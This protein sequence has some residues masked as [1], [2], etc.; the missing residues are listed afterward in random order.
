MQIWRYPLRLDAK[1]V[2]V[3]PH[4]ARLLDMQAQGDQLV[5]WARVQP[6][7][8]LASRMERTLHIVG[9]GQDIPNGDL[10][11]VASAQ[12]GVYVWHLFD[13]GQL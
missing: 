4:E 10:A 5:L 11:Y 9:T 8:H 13:G 7:R 6:D 3:M 12:M 1:Q 2:V